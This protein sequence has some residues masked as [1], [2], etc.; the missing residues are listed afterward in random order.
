[1]KQIDCIIPQTT[2]T[3]YQLSE[4]EQAPITRDQHYWINRLATRDFAPRAGYE[5]KEAYF[6]VMIS[7]RK[8]SYRPNRKPHVSVY[9]WFTTGLI[10]DENT[11]AE[12]IG[13]DRHMISIGPKGAVKS[14]DGRK[15]KW[16]NSI[17]ALLR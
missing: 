3:E 4:L 17:H 9:F 7:E 16:D 15:G 11:L 5:V 13:R 1:M 14:Y 2:Q 12:A 8:N 6:Q 10:G